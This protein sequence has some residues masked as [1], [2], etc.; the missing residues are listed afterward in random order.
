M[1]S[2]ARRTFSGDLQFEVQT[3]ASLIHL[4][5]KS[6]SVS[7]FHTVHRLVAASFESAKSVESMSLGSRLN[8]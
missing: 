7:H 8:Y 6:Q 1:F 4:Q 3:L 5:R 2:L